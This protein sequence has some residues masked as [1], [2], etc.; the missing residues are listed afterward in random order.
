MGYKGV[1]LFAAVENE[2]KSQYQKQRRFITS[3]PV[4]SSAVVWYIAV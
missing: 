4:T 2:E 3:S 1:K